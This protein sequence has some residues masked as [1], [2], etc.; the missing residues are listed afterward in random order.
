MATT[1]TARAPG[2]LEFG[3]GGVDALDSEIVWH[4]WGHAT[5]W[6]ARPGINQN[7]TRKAW[8][9]GFGDYLAGSLSKRTVGAPSYGVTRSANGMPSAITPAIPSSSPARQLDAVGQ[10]SERSARGRS[11][12]WSHPLWDYDNQVGADTGLDVA[13]EALFLMDLEP[14]AS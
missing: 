12:V 4:E 6:N 9:R 7:V 11:E 1:S 14:D 13:L 2:I 8:V 3:T 10:S 5:F